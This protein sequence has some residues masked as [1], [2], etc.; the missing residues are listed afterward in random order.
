ME[1]APSFD[2][3]VECSGRA[4]V[5][6]NEATDPLRGAPVRYN[7]RAPTRSHSSMGHLIYFRDTPV[8]LSDVTRRPGEGRHCLEG[9]ANLTGGA[10]NTEWNAGGFWKGAIGFIVRSA[11]PST[12]VLE[13][14][15]GRRAS[16]GAWGA[17]R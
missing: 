14:Y 16:P 13:L 3:E 4:P 17:V 2:G 12:V 5:T 9:H 1:G 8:V 7:K 15:V 11:L 6:L 10:I